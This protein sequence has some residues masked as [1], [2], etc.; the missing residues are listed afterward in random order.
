MGELPPQDQAHSKAISTP[1]KH[2][3]EK[4]KGE[5]LKVLKE[6]ETHMQFLS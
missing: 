1:S 6:E 5:N 4:A 3:F 2:E